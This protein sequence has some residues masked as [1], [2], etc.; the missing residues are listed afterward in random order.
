MDE[1]EDLPTTGSEREE[2][3]SEN[4]E[5]EDPLADHG[6][7]EPEEED[8]PELAHNVSECHP[9]NVS[10]TRK[11][12]EHDSFFMDNHQQTIKSLEET[13]KILLEKIELKAAQNRI[14]KLKIKLKDL[15]SQS[16]EYSAQSTDAVCRPKLAT[17]KHRGISPNQHTANTVKSV[18]RR[19]HINW[20]SKQDHGITIDDLRDC[21]TAF[22]EASRRVNSLPTSTVNDSSDDS[23]QSDFQNSK[24]RLELAGK[25]TTYVKSGREAKITDVVNKQLIW[26]HTRL[27]LEFANKSLKY[28]QLSIPLFVAGYLDALKVENLEA[29]ELKQRLNYLT[30]IMY[31]AE[32]CDWNSILDLNATVYL[33][34]ERGERDWNDPLAML[35]YRFLRGIKPGNQNVKS[36]TK[37]IR[38]SSNVNKSDMVWFCKAFQSGKCAHKSSHQGYVKGSKVTVQHICASCW[39]NERAKKDHPESSGDCKYFGQPGKD[40][41]NK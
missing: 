19:S 17:N 16:E 14:Q 11:F 41:L 6:K 38:D 4:E 29:E 12:T 24:P 30:R 7:T 15:E 1:G 21:G 18:K 13:E 27:S 5:R 32:V 9:K 2:F 10:R 22:Q 28:E 25:R 35:E 20:H 36:S 40:S 34:I 31:N 39:I 23:D 3:S 26:P 37:P 8:S 33:S